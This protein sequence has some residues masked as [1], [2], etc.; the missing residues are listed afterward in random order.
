MIDSENPYKKYKYC[1]YCGEPLEYDATRCKY[2]GSRLQTWGYGGD[3]GESS[4][5]GDQR[6]QYQNVADLKQAYAGAASGLENSPV[7]EAQSKSLGNGVKVLLTVLFSVIPVVG[8]IAGIISALILMS[9]KDNRDK[10]SFG[11]SI[12]V[13]SIVMFVISCIVCY[14]LL[15]AYIT[16]KA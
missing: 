9:S 4:Y 8:Q 10:S 1:K 2:C 3:S 15:L 6:L 16:L 14:L 11:L 13:S 7:I 12:F 5:Y